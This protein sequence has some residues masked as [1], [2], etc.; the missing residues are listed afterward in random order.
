[1]PHP[2]EIAFD[3]QLRH[4]NRVGA[5]TLSD[6]L[7]HLPAHEHVSFRELDQMS[8]EDLSDLQ[9]PLVRAADYAHG[10]R[11]QHNLAGFFLLPRLKHGRRRTAI[12]PGPIDIHARSTY[13][14]TTVFKIRFR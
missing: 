13:V 12:N 6:L 1:M 3:E 14:V 11:V 5:Q 10:G 7:L 8:P 2:D 9:A 4:R